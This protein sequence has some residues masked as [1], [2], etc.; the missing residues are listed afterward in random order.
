MYTVCTIFFFTFC[1]AIRKKK[2]D[3][4]VWIVRNFMDWQAKAHAYDLRPDAADD[5]LLVA[6]ACVSG[7]VGWDLQSSQLVARFFLKTMHFLFHLGF[8]VPQPC[9]AQNLN[10]STTVAGISHVM[11]NK[12]LPCT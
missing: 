7:R 12:T 10:R 6:E 2:H 5:E 11:H 1:F 4:I 8:E 3:V 9:E